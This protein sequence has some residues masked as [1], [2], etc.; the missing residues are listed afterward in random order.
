M[1]MGLAKLEYVAGNNFHY[2]LDHGV[3]AEISDLKIIT[4]PIELRTSA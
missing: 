1:L 3:G 2:V 4:I